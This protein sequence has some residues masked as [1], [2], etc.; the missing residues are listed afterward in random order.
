[1]ACSTF[2]LL[3][4]TLLLHSFVS[5]TYADLSATPVLPPSYPLAVRN[6]FLSAWMPGNQLRNL[7][8]ATP[9][10]WAG[11]NLT[12]GI[13]A[14]VNGNIYSLFGVTS[15]VDGSNA[16]YVVSAEYTATHTIFVL[17]A[18]SARFTLDFFSPVS[19]NDYIRQSL[20]FS[21]LTIS[22]HISDRSS[23]RIQ[24]YCD[25]D[26][27]WTGQDGST[28]A[29][30]TSSAGTS[31]FQL[32]VTGAYKYSVT[33]DNSGTDYNH[34]MALWGKVV[35]ASASS[36]SSIMT[37]QS[38]SPH[39]VR[40]KFATSGSLSND[41]PAYARGDVVGIAQDLGVVSSEMSVTFAIGYEREAAVNYLGNVRT[42]YYRAKYPDTVSAVSFFLSDYTAANKESQYIDSTLQSKGNVAGS[43][44]YSDIILLS[45]RQ[46]FGALDLTIPND[47]L[48][49]GDFMVF[50]KEISSDGDVNTVDVI[51]ATFPIF[52]VM[53]PEYI[54]LLLE[55]VVQYLETGRWKEPWV[56][57]DIGNYPNATGHDDQK[58]EEQQL[59]ETGN[60]LLL[61]WA[62]TKATA[63]RTFFSEHAHLFHNYSDYLM[64]DTPFSSAAQLTTDDSEPLL[65]NQTSLAIKTCIALSAFGVLSNTSEYITKAKDT[66]S[67]LYFSGSATDHNRTHFKIQYGNQTD[68]ND[69]SYITAYNL[70]PDVLLELSTFPAAAYDME[71]HPY[72]ATP[73]SAGV[74]LDS[75]VNWTKT[76]WMMF[77]AAFAGKN[78]TATAT[79]LINDVHA[80]MTDPQNHVPFSDRYW[81]KGS[82]PG[83]YVNFKARPVVG[84]HFAILAFLGPNLLRLQ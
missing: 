82:S 16:A 24:V 46:V 26:E 73:P 68:T 19:P 28:V 7:P 81:V 39:V 9:Q 67:S 37:S 47:S 45:T 12:L 3:S 76:D 41:T 83:E 6:P 80:L 70:F 63:N 51:Y 61:V 27:T 75:T 34:D 38:G 29:N 62:Y 72:P 71:S 49:T 54:R 44:N 35:F 36:N 56:I 53:C 14:L 21:Y 2:I 1:M 8:T 50:L 10:F 69:A 78:D 48:N 4:L 65:G 33:G 18:G 32:S 13:L 15:Q 60:L 31:I 23:H 11:Q 55:P 84:G 64:G 22:V 52:Y 42:G 43:S 30:F 59:E 79:M 25:I 17:D 40:T 77:T 5:L 66:A 20:P 58:E 74:P 57:H